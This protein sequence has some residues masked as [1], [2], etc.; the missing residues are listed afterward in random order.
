MGAFG[1][2]V[3]VGN[4][5]A[6][7][8]HT[9]AHVVDIGDVVLGAWVV[10]LVHADGVGVV[11]DGD[12]DWHAGAHLL[13]HG[14]ATTAGEEVYADFAGEIQAE[15]GFYGRS[16]RGGIEGSHFPPPWT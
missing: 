13:T 3:Q 16:D 15:L 2:G 6:A 5:A 9:R 14:C 11:V 1:A 8:R 12:I 7:S 10:A 4:W